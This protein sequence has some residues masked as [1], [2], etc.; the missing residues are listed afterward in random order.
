MP[1]RAPS[2]RP[3]GCSPPP[4]GRSSSPG[5]APSG[6]A[7][8]ARCATSPRRPASRSR[9]RAT[10]AGCCPTRTPPAWGRCCTAASASPSPTSCS[11]SAAASTATCSSA[12]S[13]CGAHDHTIIQIDVDPAGFALN[14]PPDIGL[15]GDA[16]GRARPA[17]RGV[18]GRAED[19][20]VRRGE[21]LRGGEPRALGRRD[22]PATRPA[23]T[24]GLLAKE[25]CAFAAEVRRRQRRRFVLDGGDILGW[26]LAFVARRAARVVPLHLRRPRHP[27]RRRAVRG[28]GAA[29]PPGRTDRRP[30]RRRRLRPVGDGD[31]DGGAH[32]HG[33][34]DRRVE[35]RLLGRRPLRGDRVV[36][37]HPRHRPHLRPLRPARRRPRRLR[38]A[39]R[40]ARPA[41]ARP[42][43]GPRRPVS[44]ASST[45]APTP[46][47]RTRS[48]ATWERWHCNE[49]RLARS[50]LALLLLAPAPA[51]AGRGGRGAA[52][53][54][55]QR[56]GRPAQR[57]RRR[58]RR[59][60]D[61]D[62]VVARA[63]GEAGLDINAEICFVP[64]GVPWKPDGEIWFIAGED[65]EQNSVPGRHQAGLGDVPAD[66]RHARRRWR[67]RDRQA[68]PRQLRHAGE[69]PGELRVRR[70]ARRAHRDR[71]RRRPAARISRRRAS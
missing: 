71:R 29:G 21:G 24:P 6:R 63:T 37:R 30:H 42:G 18:E 38:R 34:G 5:A 64:D 16:T 20:V 33:A 13:R 53:A 14:R 45:S 28:G 3:S 41:A 46:T 40:A 36:R 1:T 67:R 65:T 47:D 48:S 57:L 11:S 56:R 17:H 31:R 66:R 19:G 26:G 58:D 9:R 59:E 61:A 4:S 35:Q 50:L 22:R 54:R 32:R 8:A 62:R 15:L 69:Q 51:L 27:R 60:A 7:P 44:S 2:T 43:P 70:A 25:V 23:C 39:G 52:R 10:A 49:T 12:T 55:L 68:R